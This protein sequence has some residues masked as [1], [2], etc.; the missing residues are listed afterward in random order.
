MD[1]F[2]PTLSGII[3][4][5]YFNAVLYSFE[6]VQFAFYLRHFR[7]RDG[8]PVKL[9]VFLCVLIDTVC[10]I[11]ICACGFMY[12]VVHWGDVTYL[13][14]QYWPMSTY[15]FCT[16]NVGVLV[17]S[18]LISRYYIL[19]SSRIM[20][21]TLGLFTFIA[22]AGGISVAAIPIFFAPY[23]D[24]DK[25]MVASIIWLSS[26]SIADTLIA[27]CLVL[28]LAR[29]SSR[30]SV[31]STKDIISRLIPVIIQSGLVTTLLALL[32]LA[33]YLL[34]P[35]VNHSA[36]FSFCLGRVYTLTMLFSL[37]L[38]TNLRDKC[39]ECGVNTL[40]SVTSGE[41]PSRAF[42]GVQA[43]L[44][45]VGEIH[46]GSVQ[47]QHTVEFNLDLKEL[48]SLEDSSDGGS[49]I[50]KAEPSFSPPNTV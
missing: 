45:P 39:R 20:T 1:E 24:R 3:A 31:K 23:A 2:V 6:I 5:S 26:S 18:F 4:G 19:Y 47:H 40:G 10:T 17:Q 32:I 27:F 15:V 13:A 38:R 30:I 16:R 8:L 50:S 34:K 36:Y 25:A 33:T 14:K 9:V 35:T 43:I 22:F 29:A 48:A 44:T 37:N 11:A 28:T 12:S 7:E 42:S 49:N 46:F 21:V 41:T